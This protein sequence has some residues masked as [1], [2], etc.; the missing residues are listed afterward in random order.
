[1]AHHGHVQRVGRRQL[2]ERQQSGQDG[3]PGGL[4]DRKAGLLQGVDDQQQPHVR[5]ALQGQHPEQGAGCDQSAGGD[6]QHGAAVEVIGDRSA[7]ESE[8]DQR[9]QPEQA[10]QPHP[11]RGVGQAV[12]LGRHGDH[13]ELRADHGDDVGDPEPAEVTRAQGPGIRQKAPKSVAHWFSQSL[14]S[15]HLGSSLGA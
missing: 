8:N 15:H 14:S 1:M 7:P 9:D 10:G 2:V 3:R 12:D 4:I 13:G 6:D 5:T 11:G